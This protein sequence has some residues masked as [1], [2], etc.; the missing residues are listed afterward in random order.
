VSQSRLPGEDLIER[1]VAD[2]DAGI[3]S[4]EALLV[5]IGAPR[6]RGIGLRVPA[7][8]HSP[9][10][11]LYDL[12][13]D[14]DPDSAHARYGGLL[15]RFV[16]CERSSQFPP[17]RSSRLRGFLAALAAHAREETRVYLTGGATA[18]LE[19]W[20]A[21]AIDVDLK[22]VPE[23]DALLLAVSS[24]R[25]NLEI[26]VELAA[27]DQFLPEL[28]GWADRSAFLERIGLVSFYHYDFYAQALAKI[29]RGH[30]QDLVDVRE[31]LDR[32]RIG[33][34][35][36][37]RHFEEIEPKLYR[38]PAVDPKAFRRA[39]ERIVDPRGGN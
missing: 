31:M 29:E 32:R 7:T 34:F 38:F 10:R 9:E 33:P 11:R 8:I 23:S 12:L 5:S 4:I 15:R 39:V 21:E 6:L 24:L 14:S 17:V 22:I 25:W 18:I 1:G 19:G 35:Q 2:L 3:V 27:P 20:R 13:A 28:P 37:L 26:H 30:Q 16:R 36:L